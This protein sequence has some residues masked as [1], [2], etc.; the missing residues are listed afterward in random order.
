[1][2]DAVQQFLA[3]MQQGAVDM[4]RLTAVGA[5]VAGDLGPAVGADRVMLARLPRRLLDGPCDDAARHGA[6][7]RFQINHSASPRI[8]RGL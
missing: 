8:R 3:Q 4:G 1:M 6:A 5:E 2:H 7:R